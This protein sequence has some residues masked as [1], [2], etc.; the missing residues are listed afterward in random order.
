MSSP[1]FM[2]FEASSLDLEHSYPIE[3]AWSD[4]NGRIESHLIKP[5]RLWCDWDDYAED[6]IHGISREQLRDEGKT[7]DW[8]VNRM[9]EVLSDKTLHVDGGQFDWFWC[10]RLFS[11]RGYEAKLP[12]KLKDFDDLLINTFGVWTVI[13]REATDLIKTNVR[14]SIGKQHRAAVDVEF[15][16]GVYREIEVKTKGF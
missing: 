12:F 1:L 2:D 10:Q 5:E 4:D 16:Q 15:L 7:A 3:V 13:N 8:V 9:T 14:Q 11:T 6:V